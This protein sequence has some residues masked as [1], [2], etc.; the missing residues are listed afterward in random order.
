[1][2]SA[3]YEENSL[4]GRSTEFFR[5]STNFDGPNSRITIESARAAK[6]GNPV[7]LSALGYRSNLRGEGSWPVSFLPAACS[8]AVRTLHL[9]RGGT[10]DARRR[11][12]C[13]PRKARTRPAV[14]RC[15][16]A[17]D[18]Q[19]RDRQG[20]G[21]SRFRL[22]VSRHGAWC[23]VARGL[24]ADLD[25]RTRRRYRADRARAER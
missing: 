1:M 23:D 5:R 22:A 18:A 8:L 17:H 11:P 4:L 19:R 21:G 12:Q 25:R 13:R 7:T 2:I 16:G 20:H 9:P 24:R 14:A 6:T 3:T 15:R 10:A